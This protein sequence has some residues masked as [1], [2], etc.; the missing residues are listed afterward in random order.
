MLNVIQPVICINARRPAPE[1]WSCY[2]PMIEDES[3]ASSAATADAAEEMADCSAEGQLEA[4]GGPTSTPAAASAPPA[5]R[6]T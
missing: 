5:A 4:G 3:T 2:L 6:A 1:V